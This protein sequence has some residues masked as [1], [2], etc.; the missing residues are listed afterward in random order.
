M[1]SVNNCVGSKYWLLP[2]YYEL[3]TSPPSLPPS[4]PHQTKQWAQ[5]KI[6]L[7]QFTG[8]AS[9][10]AMSS[11]EHNIGQQAWAKKVTCNENKTLFLFDYPL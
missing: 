9:L 11:K 6:K 3:V 4:L 10:T 1:E 5:S 7:G 8:E 2:R